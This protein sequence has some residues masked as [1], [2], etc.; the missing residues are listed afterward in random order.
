ME[1]SILNDVKAALGI[2]S[3]E[4]SFD[5][6][7]IMHINTVFSRINQM[8][9]GPL[10]CFSITDDTSK[11][12]DFTIRLDMAPIKSYMFLKVKELFD[13]TAS[14]QIAQAHDNVAKE[15]EFRMHTLWD[16]YMNSDD[17][18]IKAWIAAN[19]GT[20]ITFTI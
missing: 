14:S 19:A 18:D 17:K 15:L 2:S 10:K 20:T 5:A 4:S 6:I 7:L 12:T 11:W 1:S 16:A 8:G 13:P 3:D 9:I